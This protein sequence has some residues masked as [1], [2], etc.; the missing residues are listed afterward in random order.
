MDV[1]PVMPIT[2][3]PTSVAAAVIAVMCLHTVRAQELSELSQPPNGANQK[4]EVSQW[5]G[6]VKVTITYHSPNVHGGGGADRTGHIWGELVKYGFVDDGFGPSKAAPWRAGANETTTISVSHDVKIGGQDL[7]AGTY[8]LFLA[9]DPEGPWTWIFSKQTGWGAYQY[10]PSNDVLRVPA[11]PQ[12]APYTE[13]LTYG[14]DERRVDSAVAFLQW[15]TKRI[16]FKVDV[17]NANEL[18]VAQMRRDLL[19]WPGFNY[20]NWQ[21]AAQFCADHKINL[22]EALVWA[23]RAIS[24]PFRNAA[25]GRKDFSTLRTKAAVLQAMG[26]D[27][28]ADSVMDEALAQPGTP[29]LPIHRYAVTLV[30]AGRKDRAMEVFKLNR[31]LHPDDTFVTYVGLARGYTA[32]GDRKNAIANWETALKNIPE[33]Q[34]QNLAFYQRELDAVKGSALQK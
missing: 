15:E 17:P 9:L 13:F 8:G 25:Q 29:P 7:R 16:G 27:S 24:E 30:A 4:A 22:D 23:N 28:D 3:I 18:Y 31:R 10:D 14:F 21:Q 2:R 11:P 5:I 34:K 12:T 33:D 6:L 32:L 19:A 20:Q 1:C 26:R